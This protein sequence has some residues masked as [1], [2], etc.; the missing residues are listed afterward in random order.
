MGARFAIDFFF[1]T[2]S[3]TL[4]PSFSVSRAKG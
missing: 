3:L 2:G 1:F 4:F